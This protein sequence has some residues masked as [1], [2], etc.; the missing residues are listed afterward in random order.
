MSKVQVLIYWLYIRNVSNRL[1]FSQF[2]ISSVL[3]YAW[4]YSCILRW[5]RK[6]M[7]I[8][9]GFSKSSAEQ[10]RQSRW[11]MLGTNNSRQMV[12]PGMLDKLKNM[13]WS[14]MSDSKF[15]TNCVL[16]SYCLSLQKYDRIDIEN[17]LMIARIF[18][19]EVLETHIE[20]ASMNSGGRHLERGH[21][22]TPQCCFCLLWHSCCSVQFC[23]LQCWKQGQC[24]DQSFFF[25]LI[26]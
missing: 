9:R 11:S 18:D 3:T 4:K 15:Q 19:I 1:I 7:N 5:T 2:P 23:V 12:T 17:K 22:E 14:F 26:L 21:F 25:F 6:S 24:W 20:S 8:C 16:D 10:S 13:T